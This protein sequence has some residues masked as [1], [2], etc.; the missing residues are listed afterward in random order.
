MKRIRTST[1]HRGSGSGMRSDRWSEI[2][3]CD[4]TDP[5]REELINEAASLALTG[6]GNR[7]PELSE[8]VSHTVGVVATAHIPVGVDLRAYAAW[9]EVYGS[10][11]EG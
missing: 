1:S 7:K 9:A 8:G 2:Q 6:D 11:A 10:G 4:P 3:R 5:R